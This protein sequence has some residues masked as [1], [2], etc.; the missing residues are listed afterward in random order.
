MSFRLLYE[1]TIP[2]VDG[3]PVQSTYGE[4]AKQREVNDRTE[5]VNNMQKAAE[6]DG[7]GYYSVYSFPDGHSRDGNIPEITTLF[8]DFDIPKGQGQYDPKSGGST[9]DWRRD[10]SELLA[11]V[12]LVADQL[13]D[14]GKAKHFRASL[15]GHKGI[16]LYIDFPELDRELGPL[17]QYKNGLHGYAEQLMEYMQDG[18]GIDFED[19]IDVTSHDLGRLARLPNTPHSGAQ[20]VDW[21]PYCVPVSIKEL[22]QIDADRYLEL[23]REPRELPDE[24]VRNPS[25]NARQV[26]HEYIKDAPT[27]WQ[28]KKEGETKTRRESM[29]TAYREKANEKITVETVHELLLSNKPCIEAWVNRDDAYNHGQSSRT[30]EINVM[31]ELASHNVP[32]DVMVEFFSD[33]PRFDEGY[34]ESLIRDVIARYHPSSF[35]CRNVV[36]GASQFCLGEECA[37]Y[38]RNEDLR[39]KHE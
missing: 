31:K 32:I 36:D 12:R 1:S 11:R 25:E 26:I 20:H 16:H 35:V 17:T 4:G 38:N 3:F 34:T 7:P 2:W 22:A 13:L 8:L 30:M 6:N 9:E 24:C 37:V 39:L 15:S 27:K 19:W 33:I 21:T 28:P 14:E 23:T 18:A 10:V 29:I 5:L